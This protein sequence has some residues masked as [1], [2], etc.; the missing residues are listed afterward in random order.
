LCS[1]CGNWIADGQGV[2][3][4]CYGDIGFGTDGYYEQWAR[5]QM[6]KEEE[7]KYY[8]EES[9]RPKKKNKRRAVKKREL[10]NKLR[11]EAQ[12]DKDELPF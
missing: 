9:A 3:S 11:L 12:T 6:Q 7:R 5:E 4:M 10:L 1:C 2:C 8:E